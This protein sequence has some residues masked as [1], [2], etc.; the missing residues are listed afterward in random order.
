MQVILIFVCIW[1]AMIAMSFWEAYSEGRNA[2]DKKKLGWKIKIGGF[3]E[4]AY[5]FFLFCVMWPILLILPLIVSGWD[6]RL[7][8]ILISA[9]FSGM[10]IEDFM[11]YVV[12]PKVKLKELYSHFSDYYPWIRF[13]GRKIIPAGYLSGIII[14]LL[15]WYFIWR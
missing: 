11:W 1:T 10:I 9:Y 13:K 7:F 5:H 4:T 2:W 8:G 6:F 3:V 14:A 15:S 12:N